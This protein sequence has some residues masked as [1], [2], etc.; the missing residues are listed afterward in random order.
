M[1]DSQSLKRNANPACITQNGSLKKSVFRPHFDAISCDFELSTNSNLTANHQIIVSLQLLQ[2]SLADGDTVG[3]GSVI[4]RMPQ[5]GSKT[6][7]I[8]GGLPRVADLFEARRPKGASI[9]ADISGI[10]SFGKETK[11][12]NRLV[13]TP[14]DGAEPFERLIP[15]ERQLSVY[16]GEEVAKGDIVADGPTDPHDLLRLNFS[17]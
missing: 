9:R 13:I 2:V 15:K 12:K 17:C 4:A 6:R 1:N 10:V 16:E 8:T 11:G 7:D 3:V 14:T 5:E